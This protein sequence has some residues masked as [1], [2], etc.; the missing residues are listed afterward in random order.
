MIHILRGY[1][2]F[3]ENIDRGLE[4]L[5]FEPEEFTEMDHICYRVATKAGFVGLMHMLGDETDGAELL[6]M[7]MVNGRPI[8]TFKLPQALKV[9]RWTIPCLELP[10][11]KP[12]SNYE[13]GLEHVELVVVG[14]LQEF[15]A[16]HPDIE[17]GTDGMIKTINPE[18]SLKNPDLNLSVKFHTKPLA[19]VVAIEWQHGLTMSLS[20]VSS[21]LSAA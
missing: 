7:T 14:K 9:G 15:Q 16:R 20:E 13:N 3:V 2:R 19:D 10:A 17:F 11:P 21:Y 12:G 5:G 8:A 18:L 1:E 6:G 4:V